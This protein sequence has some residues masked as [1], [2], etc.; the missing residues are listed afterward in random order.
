LGNIEEE[1]HIDADCKKG[2]GKNIGNTTAFL[3]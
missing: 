1:A 2:K 3:V